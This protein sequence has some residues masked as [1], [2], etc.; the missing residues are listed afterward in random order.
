MGLYAVKEILVYITA[1]A[2]REMTQ[3]QQFAFDLPD[4]V[5]VILACDEQTVENFRDFI[6][7]AMLAHLP[8]GPNLH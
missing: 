7:R 3:G 6:N 2:L 4:D 5:R 8:T 1:D